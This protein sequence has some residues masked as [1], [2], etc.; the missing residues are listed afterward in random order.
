M[1]LMWMLWTSI[2]I[3]VAIDRI[4][5]LGLGKHTLDG[6]LENGGGL[7]LELLAHVADALATWVTS[8][9]HIV[10]L[11]HLV[12]SELDLLC[13]DD[14]HVVT[15]IAV[16]SVARFALAAENHGNLGCKTAEDLAFS[17]DD[18]PFL[19]GIFL[20]DANSFVT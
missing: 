20:V 6:V 15:T 17:V 11:I 18:I 19:V 14:D 13:V 2:D 7:S 10:L 5:K 8:V 16:G 4:A 3:E 12:A 9:V 1:C